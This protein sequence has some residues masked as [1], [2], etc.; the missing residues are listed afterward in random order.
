MLKTAKPLH[1][2]PLQRKSLHIPRQVLIATA[3]IYCAHT[4]LLTLV[5]IPLSRGMMQSNLAGFTKMYFNTV[6][7]IIK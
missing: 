5:R 3:K 4:H 1:S 6:G 2:F 7:L